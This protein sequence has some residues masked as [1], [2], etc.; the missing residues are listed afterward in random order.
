MKLQNEGYN[1]EIIV[2][3]RSG[4]VIVNTDI[5]RNSRTWVYKSEITWRLRLFGPRWWLRLISSQSIIDRRRF[6]HLSFSHGWFGYA[7]CRGD[8]F[9]ERNQIFKNLNFE[10]GIKLMSY[11]LP[12]Q[13]W[14]LLYQCT[15]KLAWNSITDYHMKWMRYS[16]YKSECGENIWIRGPSPGKWYS[17]VA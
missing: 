8:G 3:I 17:E 9:E 1:R 10:F 16:D 15:L 2:R 12:R 11:L 13:L 14:T 7:R 4:A 6:G 5:I